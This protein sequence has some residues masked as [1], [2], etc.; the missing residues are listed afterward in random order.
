MAIFNTVKTILECIKLPC[1]IWTCH[2][3]FKQKDTSKKSKD[4]QAYFK[5]GNEEMSVM[6]KMR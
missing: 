3:L 4:H 1:E 6:A 2:S 5:Y